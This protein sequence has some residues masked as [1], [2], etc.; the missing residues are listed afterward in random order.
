M[1]EVDAR[2]SFVILDNIPEADVDQ[3]NATP[4]GTEPATLQSYL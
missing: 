2:C 3:F 1:A 4:F